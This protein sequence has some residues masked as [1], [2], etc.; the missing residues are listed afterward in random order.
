MDSVPG[1]TGHTN[2]HDHI[3]LNPADDGFELYEG[4]QNHIA[5][6]NDKTHHTTRQTPN[7]RH[8]MSA[9]KAA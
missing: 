4:D 7:E 5:Y 1:I 6:Y 8:L 3:Y 9:K 2:I